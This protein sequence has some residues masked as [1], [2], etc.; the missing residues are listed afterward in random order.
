M[1]KSP[2]PSVKIKGGVMT[3]TCKAVTGADGYQVRYATN[4]SMKNAVTISGSKV[5]VANLKKG[6]TYYVQARAYK[7]GAKK[8]YGAWSDTVKKKL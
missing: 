5:S 2:K 4:A 7:K 1:K 6:K 3:I 8:M